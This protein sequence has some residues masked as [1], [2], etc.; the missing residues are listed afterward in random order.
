VRA[1]PGCLRCHRYTYIGFLPSKNIPAKF[2]QR[3]FGYADVS[4]TM[5]IMDAYSHVLRDMRTEV[6]KKTEELFLWQ[7]NLTYTSTRSGL[8]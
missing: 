1:F 2:A 4:V 3:F 8:L 6:A 5:V 7:V